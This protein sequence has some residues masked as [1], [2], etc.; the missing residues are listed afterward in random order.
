MAII[1]NNSELFFQITNNFK[2]RPYIDHTIQSVFAVKIHKGSAMILNFGVM[3]K[4]I[5]WYIGR[6]FLYLMIIVK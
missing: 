5:S 1:F 6:L 2:R 4:D 3:I